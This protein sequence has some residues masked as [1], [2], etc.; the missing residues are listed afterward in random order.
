VTHPLFILGGLGG[1][2]ELKSSF[3]FFLQNFSFFGKK[4]GKLLKI[5]K[6]V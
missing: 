5:K 1:K 2:G 6:K 3:F 4:I